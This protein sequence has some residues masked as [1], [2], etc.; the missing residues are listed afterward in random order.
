MASSIVQLHKTKTVV[1]T[2]YTV[3][4][5]SR[6][7]IASEADAVRFSYRVPSLSAGAQVWFEI[8]ELGGSFDGNSKNFYQSKTYKAPVA[9]VDLTTAAGQKLEFVVH[10][11][12]TVEVEVLATGVSGSMAVWQH[13]QDLE[14]E[15]G[16]TE[17]HDT[18]IYRHAVL[19]SLEKIEE[20]LAL[21]VNH[22]R[23]ITGI[24]ADEGE[25]F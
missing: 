20:L 13:A 25:D 14:A 2:T 1:A 19:C 21:Q 10:H 16:N 18:E 3:T 15:E 17:R 22:L 11:S 9:P 7:I 5:T 24:K 8:N 12:G 23:S 4:G 6:Y